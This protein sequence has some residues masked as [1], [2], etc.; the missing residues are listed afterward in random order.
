MPKRIMCLWLPNWPSQRACVAKRLAEP[1]AVG[2][3][4][5]YRT[6]SRRGQIVAAA[7]QTA[8]AAGVLPQMPLSQCGPLCPD[9]DV[10]EHDPQTDLEALVQLA[11]AAQSFSPIV[12]IE[13]L[14]KDPWAGRSLHE[15]QSLYL[16]I[17]GIPDLFGGELSFA[18]QVDSWLTSRGWVAAMAI[19]NQIGQAW[20]LANYVH[21]HVMAG[22]LLDAERGSPV[23]EGALLAGIPQGESDDLH[24]TLLKLPI[25]S[26]RIDLAT[27]SKLHRL[28]IRRVDQLVQLPRS[29]LPSRF[30]DLLLKRIDQ[31]LG[32]E[33]ETIQTLRA[34]PELEIDELFEFPQPEKD[35]VRER[36]SVH[37]SQLCK[38]LDS[39]GHGALRLV[40]R[41]A[42]EKN[43]FD[44]DEALPTSSSSSSS[45][46]TPTSG[47]L[48]QPSIVNQPSLASMLQIGLFQPSNDAEHLMWL[49]QSQIES[50]AFRLGGSYWAKGIR[51][52]VTLSAP[53]IWSQASLFDSES[54]KHRDTIAKFIDSVSVRLGRENVLTPVT[55]PNPLPEA[56]FTWRP[57]TGWRKDGGKQEVKR[58]LRRPPRRDYQ[59]EEISLGPSKHQVWR[60]PSLLLKKPVELKV[61]E[62]GETGKPTVVCYPRSNVRVVDWT[63]PERVESGW[64]NGVTQRRDYYRLVLENGIW[65]WVYRDLT[66][67]TWFLHGV[68]D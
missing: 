33:S 32:T 43:A 60:R 45:S 20:G 27:C 44:I 11:E 4:I 53:L 12:G 55:K 17:T 48:N 47:P 36:I 2:P 24:A 50:P 16:D 49:L 13:T 29:S 30:G 40:C 54:T 28:G 39:L 66:S 42:M 26:L 35:A 6:D 25:E 18:S 23:P 21:R 9:A 3:V 57:M 1:G 64:W 14:D 41:V 22:R 52:Q 67:K 51:T 63:G 65:L 62:F 61:S 31:L 8:R 10:Q 58:K 59:S 5:L 34:S 15:P 19:G 68:M 56:T 7:N 46:A 37:V 38:R